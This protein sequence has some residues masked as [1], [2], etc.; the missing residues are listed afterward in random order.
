[1]EILLSLIKANPGIEGLQ[2]FSH[3]FLYYA[4]ADDTFFLRNKKS[5]TEVIKTFDK[6][7]LFFFGLKINNAKC[8]IADIGVK[9]GA[10]MTLC[11]MDC[12]DLMEDVIK[13]LGIYFSCNKKLGQEKNFLNHI[14]KIQNIL[15]L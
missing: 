9:K 8:E 6:F 7:S 10:K 5:A 14:V 12:T 2:F 4:S 13:I 15:K 1:M 3:K 11:G